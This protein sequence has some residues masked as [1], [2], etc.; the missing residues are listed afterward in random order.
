MLILTNH[1]PGGAFIMN[2]TFSQ[3]F[4]R[5]NL[6]LRKPSSSP[7]PVLP[8]CAPS[9]SSGPR[10]SVLGTPAFA[11]CAPSPSS[12]PRPSLLGT[13]VLATCAQSPSSGPRAPLL[14]T[15]V[16]ATYISNGLGT[17][18]LTSGTSM[19]PSVSRDK[20]TM[21]HTAAP[22]TV[23][24]CN[25]CGQQGNFRCKR[26]KKTA[27]CSVAC[28]TEDWKAHRHMCKALE[29]EPK[30]KTPDSC[31]SPALG[32][33]PAAN[34]SEISIQRVYMKDLQ[35][36]VVKGTEIQAA[37]V[38]FHSP[39]S[40]FI[41]AQSN[42]ILEALQ[43]I[44]LELQ[45]TYSIPTATVHTPVVDEVCAV[46][47]SCDM[48]WYRGL[49]QN[50]DADQKTAHVLYIDFGNEEKVPFEK[51]K[52][53][54]VKLQQF[55]PCAVECCIA[56]VVP[57]AEAWSG[58]CC[59]AVRQL[60][61]GKTVTVKVLDTMENGRVHAV[62]I[63][64]SMGN[65]LTSFL[66]EH[67]YAVKEV[68]NKIPT[69]QDINAMVS[70]SMENFKRC[71]N[72]KDDNT[73]AQVPEPLTQAVGD[74]F[75]VVVTHFQSPEKIVVQKVDN[76]GVIQ[77]LQM[78]L[79]EHCSQVPAS[80]N[81]RPAP[82]TVC[83]SLFSED[84]QWYRVKILA[85]SSEDRV[86]VGYLDFGNSEDVDLSSLRPI[87]QSLLDIP[88][89]AMTC[90]LAGVQPV[91]ENWSE[92]CLLALQ[93]R[94]S[95]RIL[96]IEIQG[97]QEGKALVTIIDEASDPQANIAE[98]LISAG[99]AAAVVLNGDGDQPIET[100][101]APE[102]PVCSPVSQPLV[103]THAEL[104][105]EGQTVSLRICCV[106]SPG[107]F[108]CHIDNVKDTELLLAMEAELKSYCESESS[109]FDPNLEEPCCAIIAE[110]GKCF[111]A[112]VKQLCEDEAM[113]SLV[114]YGYCLSVKKSY[115]RPIKAQFLTLPFLAVPCW[116]AGVEPQGSEWTSEAL[117]WFQTLVEGE[118]LS[119]RVLS[120]T[121]DGYGVELLSKGQSVAASLISE[122]LAKFP[123]EKGKH[124]GA[125]APN[126]QNES[127]LENRQEEAR[128]NLGP[129]QIPD[130]SPCQVEGTS[131]PVD[132]KT[133]VLPV[134]ETFQPCIAAVSTPALFYLFG[135]KQVGE[136]RLQEMMVQLAEYCNSQ[137]S[138]SS[139]HHL[140]K[141][142][143]GAAC[144]ARF[145]ADSNWYRAVI[146][147]ICDQEAR[148]IYVDYGNSEKVPLSSILPIPASFL[149][150]PFQI[151]RCTLVG[152]DQFPVEW[153]ESILQI[154]LSSLQQ[155]VLATVQ[156]FDGF[157]N[158]LSL[159]L[160]TESGG[161]HVEAIILDA[162]Q[163]HSKNTAVPVSDIT[164]ASSVSNTE[165]NSEPCV[166]LETPNKSED[167]TTPRRLNLQCHQHLCVKAQRQSMNIQ[168][169]EFS[170][171]W[172]H[173]A[174]QTPK[175]EATQTPR[176]AH[177][178]QGLINRANCSKGQA[179][180]WFAAMHCE[181]H[182][183]L[184]SLLLLFSQVHRVTSIQEIQTSHDN[185]N[186]INAA[187]EMMKCSAAMDILFLLDGSYSVGKGSFERS[188]HYAIK[189]S[190]ALD[191]GP[192]KV[193]VGLIQF[194]STPRLEFSLDK[195]T[196]KQ[197]L[198]KHMKKISYRGGSTQ[199]GLALKY[200]LRKGFQGGRNSS[201]VAR[202]TILLTDGR[203]QGNVAQAAAL[204]KETG[205]VLFA[206]GLRYPRWEELHDMASEPIESHVFFAEHFYD[207]ING[208]YTTLTT[209]S[210]CNATPSGCHVESFPCERKTLE[211]VK[212]LQGN[213]MC[214]KGSK[215]FSPY[216]SLCPFYSYSKAYKRHQSVC[217]RTICPDPCDSEPCLNGGTCV[218]EGPE[219]YHCV[220]PPGYGGHPHCAPAISLDCT[221]DLLFLL[222]GSSTLSLEGFLRLKSFLKRFLQTVMAN[223]TPTKVG[224]AVFGGETKVESQ[225]GVFK[226][227][228]KSLLRAVDALQPVGG[229][230]KTGQAL[231]YVTRNGFL[232]PQGF[233]DV[234]DD[235]PRVVV[236][237]TATSSADEVVEPSKYARDREIFL[238]GVGPENLK[239]QLNNIT[240][241]P[242]RT[243]TYAT[244]DWFNAKIPEL[245][246]KICSV[247]IQGCLGQAVDLVF[248][249]DASG[250][251]GK[252]NFPSLRDF[253]SSLTVQFDINRDVAQMALVT[254]GRRAET[255]FNLDTHE[256]GSSILKAVQEANYI[257]G[258]ASTGSALLHIHSNVL[259]VA[260]G[261]RPGVNKAVV[262]LTDGSSGEDAVVPAQKLRENGVSVF[263][264]G[265]GDVQRDRLLP[266]A[267][268]EE[269][270]IS[271]S[272]YEDLKYF[273]DVLVQMVC[274]EVKKPVNLCKP[275]PC[276]N[277]GVCIMSTG[278]NF[279]CQCQGYEGP[280]CEIK[281]GSRSSTRG[282]QPKPA[283][284]RKKSRQ[285]KSHKDL[286]HQ[287][288]QHRRHRRTHQ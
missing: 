132:W 36:N 157:C 243:L 216:T 51:I 124:E 277:N 237:I 71:S 58:K 159:S 284:L 205:V 101:S 193:R 184:L 15:P 169:K 57:A 222:E 287:Y 149:Q 153:T 105:P 225:V 197:E 191:I 182:L 279:R 21:A 131:F 103:W 181:V 27:Y 116:L 128:T 236:L 241:N 136:E 230:T 189:L 214:W 31:V 247:D 227:D 144:C 4:V 43:M 180:I 253:V 195:F 72:G 20:I 81:F 238:V 25:F 107:K 278:G 283:S 286:L 219:G 148:V 176:E 84:K 154:F 151:T 252:D 203:S 220:C 62:D 141:L 260:K 223:D 75:L 33:K 254:Y 50:V 173:H 54:T 74:S 112:L 246:A 206:V 119:A 111:R 231:R 34:H 48:N 258:V 155:G 146:L 166:P 42:V 138:Q 171:I 240:G 83:C 1:R 255:I 234:S 209:F 152:K 10:A 267:G 221:L 17:G 6:P 201:D 9:P 47:Y 165:S 46:Q 37:V 276:M 183:S 137:I 239:N 168:F 30:E 190:Q 87:T 164:P 82:G 185:I 95:N 41:V 55:S 265:I 86:C 245:K 167:S 122:H 113:V 100:P 233:A 264:I 215:G 2:L 251:V 147:E 99:F 76:A 49:V 192:D 78:K 52:P 232:S 70:A 217:H 59:I 207:A 250:G 186:K 16:N 32:D 69:E 263:A 118:P 23:K 45:K 73:W 273:E 115:L 244:P 199:T 262:V 64:L 7:N 126:K 5:P 212:T 88:M 268:S 187:G 14:G 145:T 108:F 97:P 39:G 56:D 266:I 104:P 172:S 256:T 275:N 248:A 211:T 68:V 130:P 218:S 79:R 44:T 90:A 121:E 26:C 200:I 261:A 150:L 110:N 35:P 13:P 133:V 127:I 285:K 65:T 142:A 3:N 229:V 270:M 139:T 178:H 29:T 282:D 129:E 106:E 140:S 210:V 60:L 92:E 120:V 22:P 188:K 12:G 114:D 134:N 170:N 161:G 94:V 280:H 98:L 91:G 158:V 117:L 288:K 66:L 269:H 18:F 281:S 135:P 224:L 53:L 179:S 80:T 102:A 8:P 77:D 249:L 61:E 160:P 272:S 11:N 125:V 163:A 143:A 67:E 196:T 109:T 271:V 162:L 259:T 175:L 85:Y 242:Q 208:L 213:F 19:I 226:G 89:Q 257:G 93:R 177:Y 174:Q 235:L 40:F 38:E 194:G 274:T 228:V 202:I 24:F 156:S 123:E 63:V 28:Q 198:K 96:R 204:L